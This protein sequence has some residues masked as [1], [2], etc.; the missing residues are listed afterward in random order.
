L[1]Y[2]AQVPR[3]DLRKD[4]V[5]QIKDLWVWR[6][7]TKCSWVS[8]EL[9]KVPVCLHLFS[10]L[11]QYRA[12]RFVSRIE[13]AINLTE[14]G[15]VSAQPFCL[16]CLSMPMSQH[17][18]VAPSVAYL[19][20]HTSARL[21]AKGLFKMRIGAVLETTLKREYQEHGCIRMEGWGKFEAYS[22][23]NRA[24]LVPSVNESVGPTLALSL[25][26]VGLLALSATRATAPAWD[27]LLD[28]AGAL[29]VSWPRD[30]QRTN[31]DYVKCWN[32]WKVWKVTKCGKPWETSRLHDVLQKYPST[33]HG[34]PVL[35]RSVEDAARCFCFQAPEERRN[36]RILHNVS[37]ATT[38]NST[39]WKTSNT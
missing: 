37:T 39:C 12:F 24:T 32:V 35:T 18:A 26:S 10:S 21:T 34:I 31:S 3:Q 38:A 7:K 22:V 30:K 29:I 27:F 23:A 2:Y 14:V 13:S 36:R 6:G 25:L 17:A 28:A 33:H 20:C 9:N 19:S 15:Q 5:L 16:A 1:N 8:S 4:P 11:E